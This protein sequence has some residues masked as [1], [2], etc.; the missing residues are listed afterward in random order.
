MAC[1]ETLDLN[2][3]KVLNLY[4]LW[5]SFIEA[6][7]SCSR[8]R[9]FAFPQELGMKQPLHR[10]KL[11]LALQVLG[12]QEDDLKGKLD[13]NWVT[14]EWWRVWT[15][16]SVSSD[17][18][19]WWLSFP[20]WLDDIGLPQYK[21]NFDEARVDGRM[22]HYMTVVSCQK[23]LNSLLLL[24]SWKWFVLYIK[25]FYILSHLHWIN[26]SSGQVTVFL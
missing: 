23:P 16:P 13:H 5:C 15:Q 4:R 7:S 1:K 6:D 8:W 26:N 12:S 22:L 20:G 14:S 2:H 24:W 21:S 9:F 25:M 10:K 18:I 11:Q 3:L 19:H 17:Y